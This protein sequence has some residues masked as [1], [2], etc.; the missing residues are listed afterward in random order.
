MAGALANAWRAAHTPFEQT[1]GRGERAGQTRSKRRAG[2]PT[3]WVLAVTDSAIG[4]VCSSLASSGLI[5]RGDAVIHLAGMLGPDVLGAARELGARV[6]A[7][8]PLLAVA[9][10]KQPPSL[11]GAA[12]S[13]EGDARLVTLVRAAMEPTGIAIHRL[14][15]VDR[16]RYHAAAA[17][18]ATGAI[19]LAQGAQ[20][21]F[22]GAATAGANDRAIRAFV[23][24]LLSSAAHNVMAVGPSRALAS[25]LLRGDAAAV[26]SHLES[27]RTA[28]SARVLYAA[29]LLQVIATLESGTAVAPAVLDRA[30]N[31][32]KRAIRDR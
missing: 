3:L 15:R 5:E 12:A 13:L 2:E 7:M 26:E 30:R 10:P 16:V 14:N 27:M 17:L 29:A 28:P 21:L 24:S 20:A 32:A 18:C 1:P 6:G 4:S 8:H 23:Q 31:A 11:R 25:P 9:D 19:A 22:A